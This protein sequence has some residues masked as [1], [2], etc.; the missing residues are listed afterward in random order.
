MNILKCT[1]GL[2]GCGIFLGCTEFS[3][4]NIQ[5]GNDSGAP[6]ITTPGD[7]NPPDTTPPSA[8]TVSTPANNSTVASTSV[9]VSGGCETLSTVSISGNITPSSANTTC[10]NSTYSFSVTLTSGNGAKAL[11]L[12][13]TDPSANASQPRAWTLNLNVP[14]PPPVDNPNWT[15]TNYAR[16]FLSGHSLTDNPL[17]DYVENLANSNSD[18][19]N[20]NQQIVIGSP[21]R[22]RTKGDNPNASN[23]PGYS[24]GKNRNGSTGLNII[25][26]LRNPQTI[27]AGSLYDTLVVTENHNSLPQIQ[28]E[29]TIPYLRHYHD[30]LRSG[31][32]NARTLFYHSWLDI[33]KSNPTPWIT[34]EKNARVTWECVAS[35]VNQ[36]LGDSSQRP[37]VQSLPAGAALVDLVERALAN[38][39]AGLT[40]SNVEKLNQIFSDNVH[41]TSTGMY[42]VALVTY[43]AV[44]RKSPIGSAAPVGMNST[45][46]TSLQTIAW[47]YVNTYYG[48]TAPGVQTMANCR[49]AA[50][51]YCNSFWT[52]KGETNNITGCTNFF[53]S[54]SSG[55]PFADQ[56]FTPYPAP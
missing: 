6:P 27:G 37:Q 55:S 34:H 49:A 45:L 52:L 12:I 42:Y 38:Q 15:S 56:N 8:P 39:V 5:N 54:N 43:A 3:T 10:V 44:F 31:N 41:L 2:I 19:F 28:W 24:A 36:S 48:Q 9:T 47:N 11:Q 20:Y 32:P 50:S 40:G 4:T 1:L 25:N 46:A 26:E 30:L 16:V 33:N 13:Q 7:T 23:W 21:M 53:G 17:I 29:N 14:A 18:N 51:T 35:K 22:V